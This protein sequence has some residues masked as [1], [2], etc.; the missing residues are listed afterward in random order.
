MHLICDSYFSF[1]FNMFKRWNRNHKL[2][3]RY[4]NHLQYL[5]LMHSH[6]YY[7]LFTQFFH[8]YNFDPSSS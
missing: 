2:S 4:S 5:E 3:V 1:W 6:P 7:F 8:D